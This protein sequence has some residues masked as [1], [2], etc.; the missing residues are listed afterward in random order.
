ME[1]TLMRGNFKLDESTVW[2]I[3]DALKHGI[4]PKVLAAAH[5]VHESTISDIKLKKTWKHL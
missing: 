2:I 1:V 4:P 5:G 3:R